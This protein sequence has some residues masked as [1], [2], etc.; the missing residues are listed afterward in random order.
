M[1]KDYIIGNKRRLFSKAD[2]DK[3]DG[4]LFK[5]VHINKTFYDQKLAL[6]VYGLLQRIPNDVYRD[7]KII[8]KQ[9]TDIMLIPK[10]TNRKYR[11]VV[12]EKTLFDKNKRLALP[13]VEADVRKKDKETKRK[14]GMLTFDIRFKKRIL[15]G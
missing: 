6:S 7:Y 1:N 14:R 8:Y 10:D 3:Y 5:D 12:D 9:P 13:K 2:F 4:L 15:V 11:V